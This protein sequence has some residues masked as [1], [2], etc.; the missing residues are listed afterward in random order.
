MQASYAAK[1][2]TMHRTAPTAERCPVPNTH[3]G[4]EKPCLRGAGAESG[5][6]E[7]AGPGDNPLSYL[8]ADYTSV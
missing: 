6:E 3:A 8:H 2:P 1:H 5:H 7:D 4:A